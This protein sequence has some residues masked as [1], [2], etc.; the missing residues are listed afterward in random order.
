[1]PKKK[2]ILRALESNSRVR[3]GSL[4]VARELTLHG[5]EF[6]GS[7]AEGGVLACHRH[8]NNEQHHAHPVNELILEVLTGQCELYDIPEAD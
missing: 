8:E 3:G 5:H 4:E 1:M 2:S 7:G 6:R